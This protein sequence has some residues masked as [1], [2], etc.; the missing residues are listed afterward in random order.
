VAAATAGGALR[1]HAAAPAWAYRDAGPRRPAL[2][3]GVCDPEGGLTAVEIT[4]LDADGGRSRSARPAR[5]LV[6]VLPAGSAVRLAPAA[7]AMVVGE[8]VFTTLS[9][10]RRFGRPG[11]A[12]LSTGNLRRWAPPPGVRRVFVAGDRGPEGE[13]SAAVLRDRLV[14]AGVEA[15]VALPPV[16]CGD[17]NDLDQGEAGR[18]GG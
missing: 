4:Y 9:A 11:W 8:G 7:E 5:K 12:L 2:L 17:W 6:G 10:M 14:E 3:A 1:A 13:R 15:E 18:K 16:G